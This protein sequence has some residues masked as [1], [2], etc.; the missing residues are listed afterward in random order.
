MTVVTPKTSLSLSP[1]IVARYFLREITTGIVSATCGYSPMIASSCGASFVC[2]RLVCNRYHK[3]ECTPCLGHHHR[4]L[5]D[6]ALCHDSPQPASDSMIYHSS[7][8]ACQRTHRPLGW[9]GRC[10]LSYKYHTLA[11]SARRIA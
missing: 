4:P 6:R 8:A 5:V 2:C 11:L 10:Q 9:L 7:L 1:S 3:I